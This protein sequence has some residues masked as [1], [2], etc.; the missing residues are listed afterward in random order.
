MKPPTPLRLQVVSDL[1][2]EHGGFVVPRVDCDIVVV[3]GDLAN[4]RRMATA[5]TDLC[6]QVRTPII[7]VPGNHDWY[8]T[9][10][11]SERSELMRS[12]RG[13]SHEL[14]LLDD[15]SWTFHHQGTAYRFIGSTWWSALDWTEAGVTGDTAFAAM[16]STMC[17][18]L[19]DYHLI[20]HDGQRLEPEHTRDLHRLSTIFLKDQISDAHVARETPI[21]VTH[22]LP[23]RS[24]INAR[25]RG[26]QLNAYFANDRDDLTAGVPLWIHGHTHSSL[27]YV[28]PT[29]CR[30]VCNPRGYGHEN[31]DFDAGLIIEIDSAKP[32][33][34]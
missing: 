15:T 30:V 16:R 27:D 19:N 6:K 3:A 24:S 14:H 28:L 25:Y 21:V 23:S 8:Q 2:I 1:H 32:M 5:M 26:S 31:P 10:I 33:L 4:G 34:R 20:R 18:Q 22:F 11:V 17:A 7:Y 13:S 9:D 12:W 29:G